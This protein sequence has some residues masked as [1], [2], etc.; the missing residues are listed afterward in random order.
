MIGEWCIDCRQVGK[1]FKDSAGRDFDALKDVS[2]RVGKGEIIGLL[3]PDGAGKTTLIRLATGLMKPSSGSI[4]TLGFDTGAQASMIQKQIGYMPQKFGL[5]EDLTVMENMLLYARLHGV[6][7]RKREEKFSS[8]LHMSSL[9]RFT[10]RLAGKLSGGMKQKLGLCCCLISSPEL[11]LLDEPTVGVDPLS[12]LELWGILKQLARDEGLSVLVS[13]SYMDEASY[14]KRSMILYEG[15]LLCDCPPS[16]VTAL[17]AGKTFSIS[18][19]QGE[20]VRRIQS[21]LAMIPTVIN[22]TPLGDCVRVVMDP[23]SEDF[24]RLESYDLRPASPDY[25]DGFMTLLFS[26]LASGKKGLHMD[27]GTGEEGWVVSGNPGDTV[28]S[29]KDLVRRFGSFVAVDHVNF[30]VAQGEI[31]GL[32]GPNGAGK[33]TTFRML[34]GLLPA[35]SG[36]LNVAGVD[37]RT[38]APVARRKIGYVAQKFSQYGNL[39]VRQN[40]NFFAGA[41]GMRGTEKK[42]AVNDMIDEFGLTRFLDTPSSLLPGGYKQRLSMACALLHRPEILFLDEATSGA[43][44]VA[45][46]EFWL[47]INSLADK[48]VTVIITTHFLGEAEYCDKMVIMM[49]GICLAQGSPEDIRSH[50][51]VAEDGGTPSL[52]DAFL[53]ITRERVRAVPEGGEA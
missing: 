35:S 32:L 47:R 14:C 53:A 25:S 28:I 13:T 16:E 18:V 4:S 52:E 34:C 30:S 46:R 48:G 41:Y 40:L 24:A 43:D 3:G 23:S 5:Y 27:W 37:L 38:A 1:I 45:R 20:K 8:L 10:G 36:V 21:E 31:F 42:R 51:P 19:P 44:P 17:A 33:S 7:S 50:A 26:H 2:F 9:Q 6:H 22:S 39:T 49:D 15:R 29:V 11:L 12:R